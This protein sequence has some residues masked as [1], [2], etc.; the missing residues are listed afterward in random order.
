MLDGVKFDLNVISF[1]FWFVLLGLL[2]VIF[3]ITY[4]V[5]YTYLG[6]L[7]ALYGAIALLL[8]IFFDR[9]FCVIMKG[10]YKGDENAKDINVWWHIARFIS[11]LVLISFLV[12]LT[13]NAYKFNTPNIEVSPINKALDHKIK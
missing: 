5:D 9:L 3:S 2:V 11:H 7:I 4:K 13:L 6:F 8:D 12:T 10:H 1:F